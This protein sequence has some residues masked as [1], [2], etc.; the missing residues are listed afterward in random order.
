MRTLIACLALSLALPF[1]AGASGDDAETKTAELTNEQLADAELADIDDIVR[2]PGQGAGQPDK[3]ALPGGKAERLVPGGVLIVS[4]DANRDGVI[5]Q[6]ELRTGITAAYQLADANGDGELTAL[7]QQAWAAG[8]PVRDDTL[9]NPVRFDPN[10]DRIVTYEE[11]YTVILQLAATYQDS[12]GDIAIASL[13]AP[14][15]PEKED[16]R[17]AQG[18]L[19]RGELPPGGPQ[20]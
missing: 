13:A 1:T 6:E 3:M 7:E 12:A 9:A 11:F 4:F 16:R 20:R 8:M 18:G 19:A 17:L 5:S 14:E 10:L 2:L 15:K